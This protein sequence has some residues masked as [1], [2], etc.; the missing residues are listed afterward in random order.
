MKRYR[1]YYIDGV[2]FNSEKE[3]DTFLIDSFKNKIRQLYDMLRSPRY[4]EAELISISEMITEKEKI[5]HDTYGLT[6]DEIEE[7]PFTA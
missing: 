1:G 7:I 4:S 3:I 5:L 6:W 2:I